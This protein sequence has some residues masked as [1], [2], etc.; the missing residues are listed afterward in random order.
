[1]NPRRNGGCLPKLTAYEKFEILIVVLSLFQIQ[2]Q[3]IIMLL[4]K[5]KRT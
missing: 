1:M 3:N 2:C 5:I 4:K